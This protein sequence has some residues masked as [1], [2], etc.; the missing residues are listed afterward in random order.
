MKVRTPWG[1]DAPELLRIEVAG[2]VGSGHLIVRPP[3]RR[4]WQWLTG[5]RPYL[6]A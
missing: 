6:A 4:F 2:K 5:K 1:S 3:R